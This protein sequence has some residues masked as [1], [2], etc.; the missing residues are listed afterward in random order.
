MKG[1]KWPTFTP[2]AT[3]QS[4]RYRGRVLLRR[5]HHTVKGKS[6]A[7]TLLATLATEGQ[8]S[9]DGIRFTVLPF[10]KMVNDKN[11]SSVVRVTARRAL[12]FLILSSPLDDLLIPLSQ[13]FMHLQQRGEI[14]VEELVSSLGT[15]WLRFGPSVL[16]NYENMLVDAADN[17]PAFQKLFCQF[18][19]L[20][21][22]MAVQ[23]WSQ[24]DFHGKLE[25]DYVIRRADN[26]YLIVEIE[27]PKKRLI[28]QRGRLSY[29]ATHAESQAIE[30]EA[31]LSDRVREARQNFPGYRRADCLTVVGVERA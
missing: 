6:V 2:P 30:Y 17:E 12:R 31:F 1:Q 27:C 23:V 28:T 18:P 20:L 5:S 26:S 8:L 19:Q 22:P 16:D 13:A 21:D 15:R 9:D 10:C 4:R 3:T 7:I 29:E 11:N 14:Q 24:P 25:P